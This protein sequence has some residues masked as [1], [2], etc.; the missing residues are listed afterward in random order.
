METI[1]RKLWGNAGTAHMVRAGILLGMSAAGM[2][3]LTLLTLPGAAQ[4]VPT[5][6]AVRVVQA[7]PTVPTVPTCPGFDLTW[8]TVDGGGGTFSTSTNGFYQL[9]GTIGQPD[10]G[11]HSA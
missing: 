3:L 2:L 11:R 10:A 6:P 1:N 8:Y 9:G 4:A 5:A 7:A